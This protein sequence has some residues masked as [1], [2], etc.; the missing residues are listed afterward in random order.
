MTS[1]VIIVTVAAGARDPVRPQGPARARGRRGSGLRGPC[2]QGLRGPGATMIRGVRNE[3]RPNIRSFG[4]RR[5]LPNRAPA[6]HLPRQNAM[7]LP[8][9]LATEARLLVEL[10]DHRRQQRDR[11]IVQQGRDMRNVLLGH[12]PHRKDALQRRCCYRGLVAHAR[13]SCGTCQRSHSGARSA[14]RAACVHG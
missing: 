4:I 2:S 12:S 9:C 11:A 13:S 14:G 1:I 5:P 10:L 7:V 6:L 8:D 3:S